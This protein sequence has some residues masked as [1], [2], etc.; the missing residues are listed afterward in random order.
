MFSIKTTTTALALIGTMAAPFTSIA[1]NV[2][3]D[4]GHALMSMDGTA[5][6]DAAITA[7]TGWHTCDV[8]RTGAGWGNHYVAMTCTSGPFTNKWHIMKDN[9]KDAMLATAL[10]AVTSG[11]KVQVHISAASS[12]YNV[13]DALYAVK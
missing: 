3:A 1:Q 10:S 11:K 6:G 2:E 8:I 13:I 12:G 9:Q 7:V 5:S 4:L